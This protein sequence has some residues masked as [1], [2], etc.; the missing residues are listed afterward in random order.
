MTHL[1]EGCQLARIVQ[2]VLSSTHTHTYTN[3][4]T[5]T[6]TYTHKTHTH[7]THKHTHTHRQIYIYIYTH[8]Y[9]STHSSPEFTRPLHQEA[10]LAYSFGLVELFTLTSSGSLESEPGGA[11]AAGRAAGAAVRT[12]VATGRVAAVTGLGS[13]STVRLGGQQL[14]TLFWAR[15]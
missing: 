1:R 5:H 2:S 14:H 8:M 3:K 7:H 4:H 9:T 10:S 6:H 13:S 11:W 15:C 12:G